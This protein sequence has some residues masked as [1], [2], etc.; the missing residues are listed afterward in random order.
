MSL[1]EGRSNENNQRA[2]AYSKPYRTVRKVAEKELDNTHLLDC[3]SC[4]HFIGS[5]E[6]HMDK[7]IAKCTNCDHVFSFE[8]YLEDDPIGASDYGI[9][10][11]G[12]ELL[13]LKS[14][15]EIRVNHWQA[16]GSSVLAPLFFAL[17]WNVMLLPFLF[18]I[19]SSGQWFILLFMSM[20]LFAGVSMLRGVLGTVFNRSMID[21]TEAGVR[22]KTKPFGHIGER[23]KFYDRQNI[24]HFSVGRAKKTFKT[25]GSQALILHLT[26]G[27][28]VHF[29]D[30]LDK[31]TLRYIESMIERHYKIQR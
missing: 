23:D 18:F 9:L 20:H 21:V 29:L 19:I 26:N 30:G 22:V 15:L 7:G 12:I 14:L 3:P 6:V 11:E 24:S 2:L 31:T 27:K 13:K 1:S 10:P 16:R 4:H 5:H 17:L 25:T 28:K 8:D